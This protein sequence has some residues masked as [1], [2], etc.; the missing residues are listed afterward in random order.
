[1]PSNL[2]SLRQV[3]CVIRSG[4]CTFGYIFW[5]CISLFTTKVLPRCLNGDTVCV[6]V[7]FLNFSATGTSHMNRANK[8]VWYHHTIRTEKQPSKISVKQ[9]RKKKKFPEQTHNVAGRRKSPT[10][11]YLVR[12]CA[13]ACQAAWLRSAV[14]RLRE[15]SACELAVGL[16]V[17]S[18]VNVQQRQRQD[19]IDQTVRCK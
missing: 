1:M 15:S 7:F 12:R 4:F 14:D 3:V 13:R 19:S 17:W 10:M 18:Y 16:C 11:S 5:V 8:L 2:T 6:Y 9:N